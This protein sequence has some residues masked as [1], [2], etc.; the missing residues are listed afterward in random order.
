MNKIVLVLLALVSYVFS[1]STDSTWI[2]TNKVKYDTSEVYVVIP[3]VREYMQPVH[4]WEE[5][6]YGVKQAYSEICTLEFIKV[7]R[8]RESWSSRWGYSD[9][10]YQNGKRVYPIMVFTQEYMKE[11]HIKPDTVRLRTEY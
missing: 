11:N 8:I 7:T 6:Y 2:V 3:V 9:K 5:A 4:Y 10:Y 1:Q